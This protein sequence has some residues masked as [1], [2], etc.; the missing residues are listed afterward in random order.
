M[1]EWTLPYFITSLRLPIVYV[2]VPI[3]LYVIDKDCKIKYKYEYQ[4]SK[5]KWSLCN[6]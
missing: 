1:V 2:S 6:L 5:Q 4:K 3:K